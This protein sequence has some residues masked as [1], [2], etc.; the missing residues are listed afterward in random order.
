[1]AF[2]CR[3]SGGE[4]GAAD[5]YQ[6]FSRKFWL[7]NTDARGFVWLGRWKIHVEEEHWISCVVDKDQKEQ[8]V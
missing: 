5:L 7:R 2:G 8:S 3:A 4:V 6:A 1:M